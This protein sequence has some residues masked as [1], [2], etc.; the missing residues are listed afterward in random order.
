MV[1]RGMWQGRPAG[2]AAAPDVG[3]CCPA[4]APAC[5]PCQHLQP[6]AP[7]CSTAE[8]DIERLNKNAEVAPHVQDDFD[9]QAGRWE[10]WWEAGSSPGEHAFIGV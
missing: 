8:A 5:L 7:C 4:G 1:H 2:S 10:R 3:C 9:I 6:G